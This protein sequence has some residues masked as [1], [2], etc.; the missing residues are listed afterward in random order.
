MQLLELQ[1]NTIVTIQFKNGLSDRR[2]FFYERRIGW[3]AKKASQNGRYLLFSAD[4]RVSYA[5]QKAVLPLMAWHNSCK[6][7]SLAGFLDL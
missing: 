4:K 6:N 3:L 2:R 7:L 5:N 1:R